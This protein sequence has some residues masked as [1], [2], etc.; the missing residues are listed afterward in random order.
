MTL[1]CWI[2][3]CF[4]YYVRTY[5]NKKFN[6]IHEL[7]SSKGIEKEDGW[8]DQRKDESSPGPT[9]SDTHTIKFHLVTSVKTKHNTHKCGIS[10]DTMDTTDTYYHA[11][12]PGHCI[13]IHIGKYIIC[14]NLYTM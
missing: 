6:A 9:I 2:L 14:Y 1:F 7:C 11:T 5:C 3:L 8:P 12:I 4:T 10:W 13:S